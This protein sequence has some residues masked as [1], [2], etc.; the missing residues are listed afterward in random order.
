MRYARVVA[1]GLVFAH[2]LDMPNCVRMLTDP[3]VE[4]AGIEELGQAAYANLMRVPVEHEEVTIGG[5]ALLHSLYG[6][7]PFVASKA[8]FLSE[9]ARQ[10]TGESLPDAGALVV[11]P[12]RHLLAYHPIADG[13]VVDAVNGLAS[14]ALGAHEDGPAELSPRVYWRHR[15]SLTALTVVDH[16]TLSFSLQPPGTRRGR[17]H[18]HHGRGDRPSR[19]GSGRPR[20]RLRLGSAL[21]T[22]AQEQECRLGEGLV[23]QLPGVPAAPPA[24]ARAWLDA[25]YAAIACRQQGRADQLCQVPL[26]GPSDP[27]TTSWAS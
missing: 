19:G 15:G 1:E 14:Y 27:W 22:G 6:D 17:T 2:A 11:M 10:V 18:P 12:T 26:A 25:F 8:L 20:R 9:V 21:F 13:S 7:S 4:H 24:D 16:D 3:D 23:R 5:R